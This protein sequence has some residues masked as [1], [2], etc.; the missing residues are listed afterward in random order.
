MP[1]AMIL[2]PSVVFGAE[3]QFF[4]KFASMTRF[5]PLLLIAGGNTRFQPVWV[6]DVAKAAVQGVLQGASGTYELGGPDVASLRELMGEML[7]TIHRRRLVLNMPFFV[8]SLVGFAFDM[9]QTV[10]LGLISNRMMTRDQVKSL[11]V[12]NVVAQDAQGFDALGIK[13][14]AMAAV[15]PD[16]LWRFR[17]SGQYDA[18]K[19]SAKNLRA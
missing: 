2:R 10:S 9:V 1:D 4:N 6:D 8:A 18:I 17:P 15:L 16:Y 7:A 5:G 14:V 11:K 12:D 13:P 3:D 19:D